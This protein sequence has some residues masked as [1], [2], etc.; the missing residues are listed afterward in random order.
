MNITKSIIA[1]ILL[2]FLLFLVQGCTNSGS[3][4]NPV[5]LK[6][7]MVEGLNLYR[8]HCANC[9]QVDGRG[10]A[11]LVPPL[12]DADYLKSLKSEEFACQIK[13]GL[14]GEIKVNGILFNQPMLGNPLLTPLEIAEI[15]TYVNNTWGRED[16]IFEVKNAEKALNICEAE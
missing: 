3:P 6:Q 4:K 12:K 2:A 11:K 8:Q 7:Y 15:I 5:K 16:G 14:D 13:Y 9:H 10:L 1:Q